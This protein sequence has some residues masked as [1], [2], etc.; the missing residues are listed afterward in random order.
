MAALSEQRGSCCCAGC[1]GTELFAMLR[2]QEFPFTKGKRP[3][4]GR[5]R[6]SESP[7][8]HPLKNP[9]NPRRHKLR[10]EQSSACGRCNPLRCSALS[11]GKL[12]S[13]PLST[14]PI[15]MVLRRRTPVG[16]KT[17]SLIPLQ[18]PQLLTFLPAPVIPA[19][20][21]KAYPPL[22]L[23]VELPRRS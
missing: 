15:R 8:L 22:P 12:A 3:L 9:H 6:G 19:F 10:G 7:P 16:I 4:R 5:G 17:E 1:S 23:F 11:H 14:G 2:V 13:L 21:E 20:A 18:Q